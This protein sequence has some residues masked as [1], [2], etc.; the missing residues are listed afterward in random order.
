MV[1]KN[2]PT[3][4]IVIFVNVFTDTL[5]CNIYYIET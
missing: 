4:K 5:Y 1:F 3:K 2:L